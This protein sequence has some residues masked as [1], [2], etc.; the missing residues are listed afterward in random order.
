MAAILTFRVF[1]W[2]A[3]KEKLFSWKSVLTVVY[4][5]PCL[6][7]G[8]LLFTSH[9]ERSISSM[10]FNPMDTDTL[11]T[12]FP[13]GVHD[14]V[15][16]TPDTPFNAELIERVRFKL[17]ILYER[18]HGF[19]NIEQMN[20]YTESQ[21]R[22][23]IFAIIFHSPGNSSMK[24]SY[25][26]RNRNMGVNFDTQQFYLNDIKRIN[27]RVADEYIE[28]GFLALQQS[29]DSIYIELI[30][31][32]ENF[33]SELEHFPALSRTQISN[34]D[35][36]IFGTFFALLLF[37]TSTYLILIPLVEEKECG[38][39]A[40]LRI[41]TKYF[42]FNDITKLIL[43]FIL[44]FI[45][46]IIAFSMTVWVNLWETI[47]FQYPLILFL[48]FLMALMSYSCFISLFF[49]TVEYAK[50]G[51]ILF[52]L[53]PF[54]V[55]FFYSDNAI[56]N[57]LEYIFCGSLFL[58]GMMIFQSYVSTG[59]IFN[60]SS[61]SA[62]TYLEAENDHFSMGSIY[63][64]LLL[65]TFVY[66]S[67]Y[68]LLENCHFMECI[69]CL[70]GGKK[71]CWVTPKVKNGQVQ[72]IAMQNMQ[73]NETDIAVHISNLC[74]TFYSLRGKHKV[75]V[76]RVSLDIPKQQI[77]ALLGHNGAGKTT[78]MCMIIGT[79]SRTDGTICVEG[80]TDP[81]KYQKMIG[82]CPQK[83]VFMKYFT[84]QEHV[85]FF[86]RL[87]GLTKEEARRESDRILN[88]VKLLPKGSCHPK[89]LSGGMKR[90][91]CL[92]MGVIGNT[93]IVILDEPTS[94]LDPESRR[95]LWDV[96]LTLRKERAVL[97][98]THYMEEADILGDKIAIMENGAIVCHGTS[99]ELKRKYSSG[100]ILKVMAANENFNSD[101]T[102]RFVRKQIS[103]AKIRSFIDPTLSICLPYE[104]ENRYSKILSDL[105]KSRGNLCIDSVSI[106]N[107]TLEEV[108]LK[109]AEKDCTDTVVSMS[110]G[111]GCDEIDSIQGYRPV[112]EEEAILTQRRSCGTKYQQMKAIICKKFYV[113][114][115][116]KIYTSVMFI[117]PLIA[118]ILSFIL[119]R[120]TV[121]KTE[122]MELV[123]NFSNYRS[124]QIH[125]MV[126][127]ATNSEYERRLLDTF[128][129]VAREQNVQLIKHTNRRIEEELLFLEYENRIGFY[130][131]I[132]AGL[133]V[134]IV[135][136]QTPHVKILYS[137]NALHSTVM[138]QNLVSN[139]ILQTI[140][141]HTASIE[142]R[143]APL[144]Q[145]DIG[146]NRY[147]MNIYESLVPL[148]L[149]IYILYFV[150]APFAEESTEFKTLHCTNPCLYWVTTFLF[151]LF[152]HI[153]VCCVLFIV[154]SQVIDHG[155][156]LSQD[157]HLRLTAIYIF[158][159]MAMLPLIYILTKYFKSMENLFTFVSY[160]ALFATILTQLLSTSDD[161][162]REYLYWSRIFHII[163]DFAM[164][165]TMALVIVGYFATGMPKKS[166]EMQEDQLNTID[167]FLSPY[168]TSFYFFAMTLF[169]MLTLT[170]LIYFCENIY[171]GQSFAHL[172][173]RMKKPKRD[174]PKASVDA[175]DS[176]VRVHVDQVDADVK[177]EEC[178]TEK[179]EQEQ[180]YDKYAMVVRN[181]EKMFPNGVIAVKGLNFRIHKG[182]CFGLLGMNGAGK[183]TAFKMMTLN[184]SITRGSI[185]LS[186]MDSIAH[187]NTYKLSYGYCPQI[188][189]LHTSLTAQETLKY[190]ARMRGISGT[191]ELQNEVDTWLR[192]VDLEDYRHIQVKFYSG[193]TK[194]KLN[195]AIAMIGSP[196]V[197]FLD[198]P[199]TG[200]DPI[201][202]RRI[203]ECIGELK[204]RKRT[205]ILTSHSMDECEQL[206][207]RIAIM[208][209]GHLQCIG[210][211]QK[212]KEKYGNGFTLIVK[213][214]KGCSH[215]DVL[216]REIA[217]KFPGCIEREDHADI[218]KYH[219]V[220]ANVCWSKVFEKLEELKEQFPQVIC[221]YSVSEVSLEDIFLH[222]AHP[223]A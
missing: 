162:I 45:F 171:Y 29:I 80:Q 220:E 213:L 210:P 47:Q 152:I 108:F 49:Q 70:F 61:L 151:D 36:V 71:T 57:K 93:K 164:R 138:A 170:F 183:T 180:K 159:G 99:L 113:M 92:A 194:R 87:R 117:I 181:L 54:C 10:E 193:G 153:I 109:C 11:A 20:T 23:K 207:N 186:H 5:L 118:L 167:D 175:V 127:N 211:T 132:V 106:T 40:L 135:N 35:V 32:R 217:E 72:Q 134:S 30:T 44:C 56:I 67:L 55:I 66:L 78:T 222:F 50:I 146:I 81:G 76:N 173:M 62:S 179:C 102:E 216:K 221:D 13:G 197:I 65:N 15:C 89:K 12:F 107:A 22:A 112:S 31:G 124:P 6:V 42:Y 184:A 26:I 182:E 14:S 105:E 110:N 7:T 8:L 2:K 74:K 86:G 199:T 24:F 60:L 120:M 203:W 163:P 122:Q 101:V 100:Y 46:V 223:R 38:V 206:C 119:I 192:R 147:H 166:A 128:E 178:E 69:K 41:V 39:N 126:S 172:K 219:V 188:D 156:I 215:V 144:L 214:T 176:P 116:D 195:T 155:E 77:T 130:E 190:F 139:V 123:L 174:K 9:G 82:Y 75:A 202:R 212:L 90:R 96:L 111:Q 218:L 148:G 136:G 17:G 95:E 142:T 88:D 19:P 129:R 1:F 140:R 204:K 63:G 68:F 115:R 97:I 21:H 137:G 191:E 16:F 161:K 150:G 114:W 53:V 73:Q 25:T 187:A 58:N 121:T 158:Y 143:S 33:A 59:H 83:N 27:N 103:K 209:D 160:L 145:K 94:G 79:L 168:D 189:A 28:S 84:C 34:I 201:S 37:M 165:H 154:A 98:T 125:L 200:V 177:R 131:N 196:D 18:V 185:H 104:E 51:G 208:S 48:L 52:Y 198:E 133:E 205:I 141:G 64:F 149:F 157:T 169:T 85:M 4:I 43:N 91:L 3:V